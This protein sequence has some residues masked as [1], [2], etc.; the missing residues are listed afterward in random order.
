MSVNGGL[1]ANPTISAG[2]IKII[3]DDGPSNNINSLPSLLTNS[4]V[5][6][7]FQLTSAEMN[8]DNITIECID[9]TNPKEWTDCIIGIPTIVNSLDDV[10]IADGIV[11]ANIKEIND[12]NAAAIILE[13]MMKTAISGSVSADAGNTTTQFKTN[14][15][16]DDNFYG[17]SNGGMLLAFTTGNLT[18][19]SK[20]VSGFVNSTGFITVESAFLDI[21]DTGAGFILVGRI[22]V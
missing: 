22:E 12:N 17:D 5:R 3:V 14:L 15:T 13:N 11:E 9:Q 2:D 16:G 6:L 4:S 21:P 8:G 20:R 19:Q 18:G 7:N 10:N 1:Q